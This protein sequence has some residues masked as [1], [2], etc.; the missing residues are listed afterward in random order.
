MYTTVIGELIQSMGDVLSVWCT[1]H[2]QFKW[3]HESENRGPNMRVRNVSVYML[4]TLPRKRVR[5]LG[6]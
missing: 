4:G 2:V 1:T 5:E 6:R 3:V